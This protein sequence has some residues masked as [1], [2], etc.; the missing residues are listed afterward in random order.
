[1]TTIAGHTFVDMMHGRVCECGRRWDE[2]SG[3]TRADIGKPNIAH[4]GDLNESEYLEI[5]V[6]RDRYWNALV[7][8]ASSSR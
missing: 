6:E 4:R 5:E 8:V 1:M 7:G 2:I 3:A